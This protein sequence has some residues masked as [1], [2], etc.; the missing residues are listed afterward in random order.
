MKEAILDRPLT[1]LEKLLLQEQKPSHILFRICRYLIS[2]NKIHELTYIKK[3]EAELGMTI[4]KE[5]W[6]RAIKLTHKLSISYRH[7]ERN[8]KILAR[9]YR[10]PVDLHKI[11]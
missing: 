9:W 11:K 10:S 2:N 1:D 4:P 6:D 7:Q 8:F 3:W 5:K